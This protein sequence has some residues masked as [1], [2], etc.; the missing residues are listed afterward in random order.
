MTTGKNQLKPRKTSSETG[1]DTKKDKKTNGHTTKD[2]PPNATAYK[3]DNTAAG[4]YS[5]AYVEELIQELQTV[6][7]RLTESDGSFDRIRVSLVYV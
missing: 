7:R 4:T 1:S 3:N 6:K 5:R 2:L